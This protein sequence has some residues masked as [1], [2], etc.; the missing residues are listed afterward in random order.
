MHRSV[1][2]QGNGTNFSGVI[3]TERINDVQREDRKLPFREQEEDPNKRCLEKIKMKTR[4]DLDFFFFT[5]SAINFELRKNKISAVRINWRCQPFASLSV[6][7]FNTH[8]PLLFFAFFSLRLLLQVHEE[9]AMKYG[10]EMYCSQELLNFRNFVNLL[11][12][13]VY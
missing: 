13:I 3:I 2:Q 5:Q 9:E 6:I 8:S 12:N 4:T 7:S 11:L 10:R 1:A